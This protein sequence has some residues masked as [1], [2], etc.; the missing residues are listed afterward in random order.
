MLG[1][2][3]DMK[4]KIGAFIGRRRGSVLTDEH[5]RGQEYS[6]D[7]RFRSEDYEGRI[8]SGQGRKESEVRDDPQCI[9]TGMDVNK[10]HASRER[11]NR[12]C[13]LFL[14]S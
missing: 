9:D 6:L 8:E 13:E 1:E 14:S 12:L 5:E 3:V 2:Q 11:G 7:G 4:V 10:P